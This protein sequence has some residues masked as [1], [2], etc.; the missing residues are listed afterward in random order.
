MTLK[1]LKFID[2]YALFY[3]SGVVKQNAY[4]FPEQPF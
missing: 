1:G 3:E 4:Q 2:P